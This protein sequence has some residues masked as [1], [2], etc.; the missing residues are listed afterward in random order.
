[1]E[2]VYRLKSAELTEEFINRLK[3]LY[4]GEDIDIEIMI[5]K[6]EDDTAYLM[7]SEKN[8]EHL[9]SAIEETRSDTAGHVMQMEEL[10]L[11]E[12]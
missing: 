10:E 3:Y 8:R 7:R 12:V 4:S 9:L 6:S 1:M 5:E 2:A 11:F